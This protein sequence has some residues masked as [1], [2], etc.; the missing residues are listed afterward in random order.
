MAE[1][2]QA[3]EAV[4]SYTGQPDNFKRG[5]VNDPTLGNKVRITVIATG[6]DVLNLPD[7][8]GGNIIIPGRGDEQIV[9][10]DP[11]KKR[12]AES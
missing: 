3:L 7:V 12:K 1:L 6:F 2:Q 8:D 11:M 5:I 4:K 9:R 10:P